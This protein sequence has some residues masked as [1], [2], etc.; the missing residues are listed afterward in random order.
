MKRPVLAVER[1][2]RADLRVLP[3]QYRNCAIA[4]G[5]LMAARRLDAGVSARDLVSL[6][7]EMR[8]TMLTL[9]E[10]APAE[11]PGS[12]VDELGAAREERMRK[13]A[14]G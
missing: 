14:Q 9:H 12:V 5:Y 1:A 7:R 11:S 4:K 10:L 6:Q 13:L 8:L 2:A 3:A